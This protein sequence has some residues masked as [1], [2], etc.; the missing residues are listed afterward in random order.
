M[1]KTFPFYK[2]TISYFNLKEGNIEER[3]T[4]K[5]I[6]FQ[7]DKPIDSRKK[8]I[9]R[10]RSLE[11]IFEQAKKDGTVLSS[12]SEIIDRP[13]TADFIPSLNLYICE[14]E[15]EE[16]DLV[17]FGDLLYDIE[18]RLLELTDECEYYYVNNLE[19][20]GVDILRNIED[21]TIHTILKDS[22]FEKEDLDK[23]NTNN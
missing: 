2:I 19:H 9:E 15:N 7:E 11:D 16:D 20:D 1:K 18:E 10:F 14:N 12:I 6:V 8:A 17:L 23:F 5:T 13:L 22:I 3:S 21:G 4:E